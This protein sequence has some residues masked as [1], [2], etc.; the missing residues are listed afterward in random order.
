MWRVPD[1]ALPFEIEQLVTPDIPANEDAF[2]QYESVMK[3]LYQL[4]IKEALGQTS[5]SWLDDAVDQATTPFDTKWDERLDRWLL[6]NAN[7]LVEFERAS[8]MERTQLISLKTL[9]QID[10]AITTHFDLLKLAKLPAT[11]AL[12][13]ERSGDPEQSWRW[14]SAVLRCSIHAEKPGFAKGYNVGR[15]IRINA[16]AA[17]SQWAEHSSLSAGELRL[18]R[19]EL[20]QIAANRMKLSDVVKIEYLMMKNTFDQEYAPEFLHPEWQKW[21]Q[22]FPYKLLMMGQRSY[23][24]S[25]GQPE[26]SLRL[27]RQLLVNNLEQIDKPLHQRRKTVRSEYP[28]VFELDAK[29]PR[30]R[31]QLDAAQLQKTIQGPLGQHLIG[32]KL[33]TNLGSHSYDLDLARRF[34]NAH[35]SMIDV[36]LAAHEFQ[37]IRGEFPATVDQMV[38]DFLDNVPFDPMSGSGSPLN[39]RRVTEGDAVI[40]SIGFNGTDNEGA[41]EGTEP[42]DTASGW[43]GFFGIV[44]YGDHEGKE[45]KDIGY[46]I[47]LK[48]DVDVPL[49]KAIPGPNVHDLKTPM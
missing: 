37:R 47:R 39:Y 38:P 35:V 2:T 6:E 27:H 33:F 45:P 43:L 21:Q 32:I 24:W 44:G 20:L 30:T 1:V 36:V 14:H 26:I 7:L 22:I 25:I 31:G 46:R 48:N 8:Q 28:L 29:R 41:I 18:A 12:R 4:S 16:Y 23:L 42:K 5:V 11:E 3:A 17:I 19:S 49:Q 10:R 34:D 40:W 9:H 13:C 15:A